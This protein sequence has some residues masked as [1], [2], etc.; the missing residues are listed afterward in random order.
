MELSWIMSIFAMAA[1]TTAMTIATAAMAIAAMAIAA[2]AMAMAAA[3][4]AIAT[5]AIATPAM[6]VATRPTRPYNSSTSVVDGSL[7]PTRPGKFE[8]LSCLS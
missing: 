3:D 7:I 8:K 4:M 6:A 1:A 5:M 2:V